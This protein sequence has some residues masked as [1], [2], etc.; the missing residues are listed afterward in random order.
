MLKKSFSEE[1]T[2]KNPNVFEGRFSKTALFQQPVKPCRFVNQR[3]SRGYPAIRDAPQ[4]FRRPSIASY[5]SSVLSDVFGGPPKTA[6]GPR[7]LPIATPF[8]RLRCLTL[9]LM[10]HMLP[11]LQS[12]ERLAGQCQTKYSDTEQHRRLKPMRSQQMLA[13]IFPTFYVRQTS[14]L[15]YRKFSNLHRTNRS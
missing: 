7:A 10:E 4:W 12:R 15:L 1:K 8:C 3:Y 9:A 5:E 2:C 14:S 13:R 6:R 11:A